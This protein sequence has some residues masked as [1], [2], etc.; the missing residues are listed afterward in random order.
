MCSRQQRAE[1][2]VGLQAPVIRWEWNFCLYQE[3]HVRSASACHLDTSILVMDEDRLTSHCVLMM[4]RE[5]INN[6]KA[7]KTGRGCPLRATRGG[8]TGES[9]TGWEYLAGTCCCWR[10]THRL[11]WFYSLCVI[12]AGR[13]KKTVLKYSIPLCV[14]FLIKMHGMILKSLIAFPSPPPHPPAKLNTF[15]ALAPALPS[16]IGHVSRPALL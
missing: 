4:L 6:D 5:K 1:F 14:G 8:L 11:K 16:V 12:R 13:A 9:T 7:K 2:P 3:S 15:S 10:Y